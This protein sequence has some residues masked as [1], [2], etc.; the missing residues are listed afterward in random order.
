MGRLGSV[1]H[2]AKHST[3]SVVSPISCTCAPAEPGG[4][5]GEGRGGM[6]KDEGVACGAD[7]SSPGAAVERGGNNTG[8]QGDS[9][10]L[11]GH[12]TRRLCHS[13]SPVL[14]LLC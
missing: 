1:A 11:Q 13:V 14:A 9:V 12:S 6:R 3:C 10:T 5:G 7:Y 8:N 2:P 4:S